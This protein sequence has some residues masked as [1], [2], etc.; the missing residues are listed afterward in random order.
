MLCLSYYSDFISVRL[1]GGNTPN[2][3][4]IEIKGSHGIWGGICDD[5]WNKPD[6]DVVCRM[7]GYPF[8]EIVYVTSKPFGHGGHHSFV[9]D[10][11]KCVGNETSVFDCP[12]RP[13]GEENCGSSEWAG[14]KCAL[15]CPGNGTC[16]D[17]G[18]CDYSTGNCTCDSGFYGPTCAGGAGKEN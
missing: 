9:L 18:T 7:L 3:G 6:A 4:F 1:E 13:E 5:D 15:P 12:A 16:S 11:V 2:E 14:V 10:D 17:Q 8:A